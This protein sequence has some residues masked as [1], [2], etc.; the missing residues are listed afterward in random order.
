[1]VSSRR[2]TAAREVRKKRKLEQALEGDG[3]LN[4]LMKVTKRNL[5]T[6]I[7]RKKK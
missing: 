3:I 1:V 2:K 5:Q 6:A 4:L 7:K